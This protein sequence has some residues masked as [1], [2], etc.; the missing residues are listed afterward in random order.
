[1]GWGG[2]AGN[3]PWPNIYI[4]LQPEELIRPILAPASFRQLQPA[5][6]RFIGPLTP[7]ILPSS[8]NMV[9]GGG[10]PMPKFSRR[11]LTKMEVPSA[12]YPSF[13]FLL[14]PSA[15]VGPRW[16][17]FPHILPN[18]ENMACGRG[19]EPK[20]PMRYLSK[21]GVSSSAYPSFSSLQIPPASVSLRGI[22]RRPDTAYIP[23]FR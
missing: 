23:R 20:F 9:C 14:L 15:S 8:Y 13:N 19:R 10:G 3:A 7:N 12:D 18:S 22:L 2:V 11:N 5:S 16:H 21:I 1:M 17:P 4:K 6:V